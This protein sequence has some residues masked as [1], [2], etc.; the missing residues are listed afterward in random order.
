MNVMLA[1]VAQR[2]NEVGLRLAVGATQAAVW[3]QFLGEAVVLSLTGALAG[4]LLSLAGASGFEHATS[5]PI[6]IS[7]RAVALAVVS[8]VGVGLF[9]GSYPA[10]RAARVDP[11]EALRHE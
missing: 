7:L 5:W 4:I 11:I 1:S 6:A 10:W 2:T 3:L 8:A 9:F